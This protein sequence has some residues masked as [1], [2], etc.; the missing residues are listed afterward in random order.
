M[1]SIEQ[2][3]LTNLIHN[4]TYMRKVTPFLKEEYF[5]EPTT[6]SL[7]KHITNFI[8]KY[9]SQPSKEALTIAFHNDKSLNEDQYSDLMNHLETLTISDSNLEWLVD[10]TERYCKD[11]AVYNAI[12]NSISIIDGRDKVHS[13]DGIPSLLQDALSVCF[14]TSIGHDYLDDAEN[15]FEF[16]NR[17]EARLPFDLHYMNTITNNGIPN[18]TLN[19]V[20]SGTGGGKSLFLCHVAASYLKQG[21]N[22]LYRSIQLLG[23][24]I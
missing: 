20:L 2:T 7:F 4:E 16:Y 17:V 10:E 1:I 18:K 21:K 19:I 15:R 14:D 12:V 13:K 5:A 3:I 22:V 23:N 9:N 6:K 11:R 8:E 24:I